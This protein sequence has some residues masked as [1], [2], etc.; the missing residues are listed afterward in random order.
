[1]ANPFVNDID[2]SQYDYVQEIDSMPIFKE[3]AWDF[4]KDTFKTNSLNQH[5]ITE[6]NEA[7]KIWIYKTLKTER[8]RYLIYSNG[9]GTELEQ[10]YGK[11]NTAAT[12]L[13][14]QRYI[15][16]GLLVNPYIKK[17]DNISIE[18]QDDIITLNITLTSIYG[19]LTTEVNI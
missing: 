18:Q 3:Y 10:F 17:I 5:I 1:M 9:Y 15:K 19:D 13:Y 7:L 4:T 11:P 2:N 12:A 6:K 16:E 14:M 8:Y